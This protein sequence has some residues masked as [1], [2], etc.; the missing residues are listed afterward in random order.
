MWAM[1]KLNQG[2]L[3]V[4]KSFAAAAAKT[5]QGFAPLCLLPN[6][7]ALDNGKVLYIVGGRRSIVG[8]MLEQ[9]GDVLSNSHNNNVNVRYDWQVLSTEKGAML[10]GGTKATLKGIKNA[11]VR[12]SFSSGKSAAEIDMRDCFAHAQQYTVVT[13]FAEATANHGKSLSSSNVNLGDIAEELAGDWNLGPVSKRSIQ[14]RTHRP[15]VNF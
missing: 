13:I 12:R 2:F 11:L 15:M 4:D 9:D 5:G 3:N 10:T 7:V 14:K 6:P 8:G 1:Y